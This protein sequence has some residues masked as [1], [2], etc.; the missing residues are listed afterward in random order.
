MNYEASKILLERKSGIFR[1]T[2][3]LEIQGYETQAYETQS[4]P[5]HMVALIK[6]ISGTYCTYENTKAHALIG[7]GLDSYVHITSPIRRIVDLCNLIVLQEKYM[8]A[9]AKTFAKKWM[10]SV[11]DINANMKNIKRVQNNCNL[12][13][14]YSKEGPKKYSGMLFNKSIYKEDILK[15]SIYIPALN[16]VSTIKTRVKL[17]NYSTVV[18]STHAFINEDNI[19]KKIRFQII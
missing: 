12:L 13:S 15:F 7:E 17:D 16:M 11:D 8:S 1:I 10:D 3:I 18:V 9:T 4:L 2:N 14:L 6:N 19:M 5:K